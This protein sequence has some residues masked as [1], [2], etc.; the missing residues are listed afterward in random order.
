MVEPSGGPSRKVLLSL[1]WALQG[2]LLSWC[3]LQLKGG[4][5]TASELAKAIL[6]E[7]K[8][9]HNYTQLHTHSLLPL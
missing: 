8:T 9:T 6:T 1:Y 3:Y 5:S 4:A 7:C 2:N